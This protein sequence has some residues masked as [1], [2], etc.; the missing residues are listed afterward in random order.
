MNSIVSSKIK[1]TNFSTNLFV[2][3]DADK[4]FANNI[5]EKF[6]ELTNAYNVNE[7]KNIVIL[8]DADAEAIANLTGISQ[9]DKELLMDYVSGDAKDAYGFYSKKAKSFVFIEKNH[10]RKDKALEGSLEEQGAD[11]LAHEFGHLFGNTKSAENDFRAAYLKD[12]KELAKQLDKNPDAKIGNSDMTYAE[13][14]KYFDHYI[15]GVDF[16]DGIDQKD[17][18]LTGAKENYA[19][20]FSILNDSFDNESNNIFTELFSNTMEEVRKDCST[21]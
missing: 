3:K 5:K 13:A 8:G 11:T 9:S 2:S 19:E 20:A 15:E 1:T 18:T 6:K 17:I 10:E 16:S 7:I 14:I 21:N 4:N 12:L